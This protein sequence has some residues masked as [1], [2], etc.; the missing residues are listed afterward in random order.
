MVPAKV[1]SVIYSEGK[2]ISFYLFFKKKHLDGNHTVAPNVHASAYAI[3]QFF[4]IPYH[5]EVE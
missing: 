1:G 3:E 2:E 5:K 4:K